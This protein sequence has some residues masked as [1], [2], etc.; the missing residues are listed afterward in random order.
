M[1]CE[2]ERER[3]REDVSQR[4]NEITTCRIPEG[5]NLRGIVP[6]DPRKSVRGRDTVRR[7]MLTWFR[8][9]VDDDRESIYVAAGCDIS[10]TTLALE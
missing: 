1:A 2:R 8:G 3:E 6:F 9:P 5:Q 7:A 4:E 10:R